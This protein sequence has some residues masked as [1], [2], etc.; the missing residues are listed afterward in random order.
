LGL[1]LLAAL[2]LDPRQLRDALD[3]V[4]DLAA[5]LGPELLDVGARV[6]E[7]V[8]QERRR[9]RLLVEMQLRADARDAERVM[10]ELLAGP[11]DLPLVRTVGELEGP[12]KQ[13]TVDLG[14]VVG[15]LGDELLDE[16]FVVSLGVEDAHRPS[17]LARFSDPF[18]PRTRS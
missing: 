2:E 18:S 4:G 1:G 9:D 16:V 12:P 11:A 17:V 5:E 15:D 3:E 14:V 13:V 8:V 6:L 7:D 10:D